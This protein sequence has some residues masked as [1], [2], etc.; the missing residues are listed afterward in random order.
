MPRLRQ[1]IPCGGPLCT[2]SLYLGGLS[3]LLQALLPPTGTPSIQFRER[4]S[5][6]N[7]SRDRGGS[8]IRRT[9]S[10]Q[11]PSCGRDDRV[12]LRMADI[13]AL[14]SDLGLF[15]RGSA[16]HHAGEGGER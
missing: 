15:E 2:A 8:V 9:R 10:V 4:D 1:P 13:R 6:K 3:E 5:L 14:R 12:V 16:A 7:A 11:D